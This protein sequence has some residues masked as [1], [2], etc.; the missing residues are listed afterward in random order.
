MTK[1]QRDLLGTKAPV[2]EEM[3]EQVSELASIVEK[4]HTKTAYLDH[5]GVQVDPMAVF[6]ARVEFII[7]HLFPPNS[8]ERID[9]EKAWQGEVTEILAQYEGML[10]RARLAG[11]APS[12]T[13]A[14]NV[15]GGKGLI[16]P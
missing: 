16:L 15:E 3:A 13:L 4:N 5:Y 6:L 8:Q 7:D 12:P 1:K 9:F 10:N 14:E 2:P 11:N